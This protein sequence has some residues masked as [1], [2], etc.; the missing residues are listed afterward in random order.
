MP[1][2]KKSQ[3]RHG[4]VCSGCERLCNRI[5]TTLRSKAMH[6]ASHDVDRGNNT[7]ESGAAASE[8]LL[9]ADKSKPALKSKFTPVALLTTVRLH[10]FTGRLLLC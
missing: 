4:W 2:P 7:V 8:T 6:S 10:V 1:S 9:A 5:L 3:L